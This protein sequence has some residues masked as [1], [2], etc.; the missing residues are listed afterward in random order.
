MLQ[1]VAKDF[2]IIVE[3][4]SAERNATANP[5]SLPVQM[6]DVMILR[7]NNSSE[8]ATSFVT[9]FLLAPVFIYF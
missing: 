6:K 7:S 1:F 4:I 2:R 5:S 9:A 8:K 3:E